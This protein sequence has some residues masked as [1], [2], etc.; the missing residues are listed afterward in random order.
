MAEH[1]VDNPAY[2]GAEVEERVELYGE[3]YRISRFSFS[4][5]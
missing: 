2:L 1:G 4:P 3:Y 5:P